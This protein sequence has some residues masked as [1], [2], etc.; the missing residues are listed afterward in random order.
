M[1][2]VV[3]FIVICICSF[4]SIT[5]AGIGGGLTKSGTAAAQFLK[6]QVGAR[7]IG[8]GGA[9]VAV[10]NDVSA[11]YWNPAGLSRIGPHGAV[12]FSHTNWLVDTKFNFAAVALK[13]GRVGTLGLSFTAL[14]MPDLKVR[15][16][17]E[18]EGTGEYFSALDI[19]MGI[20]YARSIT[21]RFDLG[22]NMKYLRE[23]IWHMAA[24]TIAFDLGILFQTDINWLVLGMSISNFGPKIQY[25]G[26]DVFINYDFD[27]NQWGDNENIFANL[28]TDSWDLPLMFRFGLAMEIINH[29]TNQFV[30]SVEA[31]HPNDNTESVCVGF[32]YGFL[33]RFFI[34]GGY[35]SLFEAD[36]EKGLTLGMGLVYYLSLK[37]PLHFD[38]AYANWGKLTNVH[39]FSLEIRF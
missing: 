25:V 9:Y 7:A 31:R 21:D 34:R 15:T 10:V 39:R 37:N 27:P 1:K 16:E 4:A 29:E 13:V 19:A 14:S 35:Q 3:L 18:P 33:R 11:I 17:F 20:S 22:F 28:Q 23:Q 5:Y 12:T 38:Y 32:E 24:S 8:M 36:S 6:I 30:A 2:R 26:K